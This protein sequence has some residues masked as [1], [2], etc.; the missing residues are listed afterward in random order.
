[1]T[2]YNKRRSKSRIIS[3]VASVYYDDYEKAKTKAI[4]Q[5]KR[6]ELTQETEIKKSAPE[7]KTVSKTKQQFKPKSK[8]SRPF[9]KKTKQ[10]ERK[11]KLGKSSS[12]KKFRKQHF[13]RQKD[14]KSVQNKKI[15]VSRYNM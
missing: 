13:R 6:G 1:M 15:T 9:I 12:S 2:S 4:L 5:K 11:G 7:K 10:P 8:K 3:D 14:R